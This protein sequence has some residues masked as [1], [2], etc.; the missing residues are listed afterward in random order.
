[1]KTLVQKF[2]GT[3]VATNSI[4]QKAIAHVADAV[5]KG[6]RVVTVVSA[7]G[8]RGDSYATDQLLGIVE[9]RETVDR[10]VDILL[11]CGEAISAVVF[12]SELREQGLQT[13]VLSGSQAGIV[14]DTNHGNARI[15]RVCTERMVRELEDNHVVVVMGFQGETESGDVTTLGRGGSDTTAT[16]IGTALL[17]DRVEIFSDVDG[18]FTADPR[19]V[20]TATLLPQLTYSEACTMAA[21]GAKVIHPRAV[22]VAM[23]TNIPVLVRNTSTDA[24]GTNIG[25]ARGMIEDGQ[26]CGGCIIGIAHETN[27]VQVTV[28]ASGDEQQVAFAAVSRAGVQPEFCLAS[29]MHLSFTVPAR[30]AKNVARCLNETLQ[31]HELVKN[32]ARVSVVG[33]RLDEIPGL[34]GRMFETLATARVHVLQSVDSPSVV[35]VLVPEPDVERAVQALHLSLIENTLDGFEPRSLTAMAASGGD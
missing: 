22:E 35:R 34:M 28:R 31:E 23:Q 10:D 24:L 6:Y 9:D 13:T 1:M 7:M 20:N 32:C 15:L 4:R 5:L 18:I 14:T 16:A 2:G 27:R 8:R 19:L 3:S 17:A 25:A 30:D 21:E 11:S 29:P 33:T 12:A 26:R